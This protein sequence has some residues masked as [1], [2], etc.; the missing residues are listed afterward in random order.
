MIDRTIT[1]PIVL[2][3]LE[4]AFEFCN[5]DGEQQAA[6]FNEIA[7]LTAKWDKLFCFQLQS[8]TDCKTLNQGGRHIME[9]IGQ[10]GE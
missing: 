8:I 9:S 6:F 3:P 4:A 10:Y 1:I 5:W 7:E 2:S